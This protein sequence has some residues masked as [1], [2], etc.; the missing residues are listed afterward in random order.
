MR[1]VWLL[2]MGVAAM[3]CP[4]AGAAADG[5]VPAGRVVVVALEGADGDVVAELLARDALPHLQG[6]VRQ[7]GFAPLLPPP[8]PAPEAAWAALVTGMDP[9]SAGVTGRWWRRPGDGAAV[10]VSGTLVEEAVGGWRSRPWALRAGAVLLVLVAVVLMRRHRPAPTA[11]V[12]ALLAAGALLLLS[13]VVPATRMVSVRRP[14]APTFWEVAGAAGVPAAAVHVP[15]RWPATPAPG[16]RELTRWEGEQ[17]GA[18]LVSAEKAD[19]GGVRVHWQAPFL[20][21]S[22]AGLKGRVPHSAP[23]AGSAGAQSAFGEWHAVSFRGFPMVRAVG[24]VRLEPAAS[25]PPDAPSGV[26]ARVVPHPRRLPGELALSAPREWALEAAARLGPAVAGWQ[27]RCECPR[28]GAAGQ[29]DEIDRVRLQEGVEWSRL[30]LDEAL[31]GPERLV[32]AAIPLPGEVSACGGGA[33]DSI[34]PLY[35][36]AEGARWRKNLKAAYRAADEVVGA[37]RRKLRDED[38]LLVVSPHGWS[39]QER[40]FDLDAWLEQQ[41]LLL[42][43]PGIR[44][45]QHDEP[46]AGL[47]WSGTSAYTLGEAGIWLNLRPRDPQGVVHVGL[48]AERLRRRLAVSLEASVDPVTGRRPVVR[49]WL[50]EEIFRRAAAGAPDL[51]VTTGD[52]YGVAR[53]SGGIWEPAPKP[54]AAGSRWA[55]PE[56]VPGWVAVSLPLRRRHLEVMDV[57]A[58]VLALL[59]VPAPADMAG[60]PFL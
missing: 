21:R 32:V 41:G 37:A 26:Q 34:H 28:D 43:L 12:A 18:G 38:V 4:P 15:G 20:P 14:A 35:H 6:L 29:F 24:W 23:A 19:R 59:E 55:L 51:V 54:F 50:Q 25:G 46:L 22:R 16:V 31:S 47:D 5:G 48:E 57:P 2:S 49:V 45:G 53:G 9:G 7:G 56:R 8:P 60:Q 17:C 30:I 11:G 10:P 39:R 44:V 13:V 40:I 42:R 1:A 36:T 3:L 27:S 33:W 52:G 58:T